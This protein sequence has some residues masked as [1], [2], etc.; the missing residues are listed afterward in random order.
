MCKQNFAVQGYKEYSNRMADELLEILKNSQ[1]D[2]IDMREEINLTK[3]NYEKIFYRT[4]HHWTPENGLWTAG[5][6]ADRLN[7]KKGFQIDKSIYNINNYDEYI[8]PEEYMGSYGRTVTSVYVEKDKMKKLS[9]KYETRIERKIPSLQLELEGSFE[10]VMYDNTMWPHYNA[11]NYSISAVKTYYNKS[12][13]AVNKKVLLLTDSIADVVSPFLVCG[14]KEIHEI[15]PRC[16]NGSIETYIK[17]YQPDVVIMIYT[18]S[19]LGLA[20]SGIL[21]ELY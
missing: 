20:G 7:Q 12:E 11:W 13:D 21:Y 15:D 3:Q 14:I 5:I 10:E 1:V 6:I 17:E 8:I 9:P 2:C 18:A 16:F 19:G 4:D